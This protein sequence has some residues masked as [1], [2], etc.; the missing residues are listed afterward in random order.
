MD[1]GTLLVMELTGIR[2]LLM[3][4]AGLFFVIAVCLIVLLAVEIKLILDWKKE[5]EE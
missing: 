3:I 2:H 4:I 1:K 5:E